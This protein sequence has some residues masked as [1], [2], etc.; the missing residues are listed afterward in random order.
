MLKKCGAKP[1]K[2]RMWGTGPKRVNYLRKLCGLAPSA[3]KGGKWYGAQR[4]LWCTSAFNQAMYIHFLNC[5]SQI[6]IKKKLK[7][8]SSDGLVQHLI[9]RFQHMVGKIYLILSI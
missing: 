6:F 9:L 4:G 3:G 8:F 2:I 1:S 5:L 7:F